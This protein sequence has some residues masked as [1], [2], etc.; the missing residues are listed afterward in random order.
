MFSRLTKRG[1][2]LFPR[3]MQY[4]AKGSSRVPPAA[5]P[6]I[7]FMSTTAKK[8][9]F[10][11]DVFNHFEKE[12]NSNDSLIFLPSAPVDVFRGSIDEIWNVN[13]DGI[14]RVEICGPRLSKVG[15]NSSYTPSIIDMELLLRKLGEKKIKELSLLGCELNPK[16][17]SVLASALIDNTSLENLEV[18]SNQI[19]KTGLINILKGL[20]QNTGLKV[21]LSRSYNI[22]CYDLDNDEL[23]ALARVI[24]RNRSLERIELPENQLEDFAAIRV[25]LE[26]HYLTPNQK[27]PVI[28]G[29][30]VS[31]SCTVPPICPENLVELEKLS[32]HQFANRIY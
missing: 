5:V 23:A 16:T 12:S 30:E 8:D 9:T 4:F 19:G 18:T 10:W 3:Q 26:P 2:T 28:S 11:V 31:K 7:A 17:A 32:S 6:S 27:L 25:L 20:E 29:L 21:F 24:S 15:Y 13:L 1:F 14:K 22:D